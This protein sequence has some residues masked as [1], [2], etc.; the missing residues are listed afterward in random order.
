[1]LIGAILT[2]IGAI[3]TGINSTRVKLGRKSME[4][5]DYGT[6]ISIIGIVI[7]FLSG[8]IFWGFMWIGIDLMLTGLVGGIALS[9]MSDHSTH[10]A[11]HAKESNSKDDN[12]MLHSLSDTHDSIDTEDGE[13]SLVLPT[14]QYKEQ[15]LNTL[16][17]YCSRET[18]EALMDRWSE[19]SPY[20]AVEMEW[21]MA[22]M[23]VMH[24]AKE[25]G[26]VIQ[27]IKISDLGHDEFFVQNYSPIGHSETEVKSQRLFINSFFPDYVKT[28][29]SLLDINIDDIKY[30]CDEITLEHSER[31]SIITAYFE[32][33]T[34]GL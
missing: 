25:Y 5:M 18:V 30:T 32:L 29:Q 2:A 19:S 14:Q 8:E 27:P 3:V 1:M 16:T 10:H 4:E 26:L 11:S 31:E 20:K 33:K 15:T 9:A 24:T 23:R 22:S 21:G 12:L 6:I 28:S 34:P 7:I 13:E 17:K